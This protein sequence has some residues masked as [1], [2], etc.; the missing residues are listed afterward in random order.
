MNIKKIASGTLVTTTCLLG[1]STGFALTP[2][3][4]RPHILFLFPDDMRSSTIHA[5]G[6]DEIITPNL[7]KL[8]QTGSSYVNTYIMGGSCPAVS[9]PSR[10][11]LMTGRYLFS[12]EQDGENIP[13]EHIVLGEALRANGYHTY[14]IGKWHNGRASLNRGFCA[15]GEIFLDIMDHWNTPLYNYDPTG[16]YAAQIPYVA[17]FVRQT[18]GYR[19][20]DHIHVGKHASEVF[21]DQA[22]EFIN[23]YDD[24]QNPFFMYVAY[25]APHD[26]RVMPE[27]YLNMYD[28]AKITIPANF[29]PEHPFDNGEMRIRDELLL[30]FPRNRAEVKLQIRSYYGMITHLDEQIGRVV[31]ALKQKGLYENTIIIFAADNGLAVGQHG[32]L[33]KQNLYEHSIKVPLIFV[34]KGFKAGAKEQR[35]TYLQDIYPTICDLTQTAIPPSVEAL[36]ILS[37]AKREVMYHAYM[38][39]QRAIKRGTYKLIEYYVNN[40]VT[41]QLFDLSKDPLEINNLVDDPK[42]KSIVD[43]LRVELRNQK[44]IYKDNL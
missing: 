38:N 22:I 3:P 35:L 15:G 12:L 31:E 36:S 33:G 28:T 24:T 41:T 39:L 6:N 44:N 34:G 37:G 42:Y 14:L 32:L 2:N 20:G 10:A 17:D 13:K 29:M 30:G 18:V 21:S 43:E 25:T 16:E 5:L 23:N 9:M 1:N 4:Q 40:K 11:M 27:K 8:V 7:D 19:N 26:P